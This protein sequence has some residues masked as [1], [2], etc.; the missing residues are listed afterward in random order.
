MHLLL[1]VQ[2]TTTQLMETQMHGLTLVGPEISQGAEMAAA[3]AVQVH[4]LEFARLYNGPLD[5]AGQECI[6]H[7]QVCVIRAALVSFARPSWCLATA[8]IMAGMCLGTRLTPANMRCALMH[9]WMHAASA[10][11]A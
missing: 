1:H 8:L 10:S 5:E 9:Q 2:R 11:T 6:Y 3:D 4:Y 7:L